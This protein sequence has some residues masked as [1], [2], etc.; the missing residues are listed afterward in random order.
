MNYIINY[1]I[2]IILCFIV[3]IPFDFIS[4]EYRLYFVHGIIIEEKM[5]RAQ[6]IFRHI[7]HIIYACRMTFER[8]AFDLHCYIDGK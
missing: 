2:F 4:S 6:H 8:K 7:V 5:S 1:I 3:I